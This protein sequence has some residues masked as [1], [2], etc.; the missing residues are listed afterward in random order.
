MSI[1]E[2]K[3]LLTRSIKHKEDS[4]TEK[5]EASGATEHSKDCN[6]WFNWLH[7]RK[8]LQNYPTYTNVK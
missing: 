2:K 5:W 7:T 4:M 3:G 8:L 1:R 6:G